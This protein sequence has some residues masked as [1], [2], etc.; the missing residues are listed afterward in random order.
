ML[1]I[2]IFFA[3]EPA[4]HNAR[5]LIKTTS[6]SRSNAEKF[7]FQFQ[8]CRVVVLKKDGCRNEFL[9]G[10]ELDLKFH[11]VRVFFGQP[12]DVGDKDFFLRQLRFAADNHPIAD[13]VQSQNVQ[14]VAAADTQPA[15]LSDGVIYQPFVTA[16]NFAVC[17]D[18][19][20]GSSL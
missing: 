6:L 19:I 7:I 11:D 3:D 20:S 14:D 10:T 8:F 9:A 4:A 2:R 5:S 18:D 12:V 17:R 15:A 13:G 1:K 16:E